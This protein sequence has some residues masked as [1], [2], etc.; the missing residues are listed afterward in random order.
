MYRFISNLGVL[1]TDPCQEE[2]HWKIFLPSYNTS[3][4]W[5]PSLLLCITRPSHKKILIN[6]SNATFHARDAPAQAILQHSLVF[7]NF[8]QNR[9][10]RNLVLLDHQCSSLTNQSIMGP[11]YTICQ[12]SPC[13]QFSLR[14]R[15]SK[16]PKKAEQV[17]SFFVK[18]WLKMIA[19]IAPEKL[20][21]AVS[22]LQLSC[23]LWQLAVQL[24]SCF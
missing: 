1:Y 22:Q 12:Y 14:K 6:L 20:S 19:L 10:T 3:I 8:P 13:I 2:T 15:N 5:V 21:Q 23:L 7:L 18:N 9:N 4:L 24:I 17:A 16:L 11:T